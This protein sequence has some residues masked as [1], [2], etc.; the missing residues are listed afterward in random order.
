MTIRPDR[1]ERDDKPSQRSAT[2]FGNQNRG[3]YHNR[4][5]KKAEGMAVSTW[6]YIS[7]L[8]VSRPELINVLRQMGQQ[9]KWPQKMKALDSFRNP[10]FWC[11]FHRDHSHKTEDCIALKIDVSELLRKGHLREFLSEK[12]KSHLSD[13]TMGRPTEAAPI[14]QPRQDRV[15]HVISGATMDELPSEEVSAVEEGETWMTPLIRYLE[16]DILPEDRSEARKI[17]NQDAS[18]VIKLSP[19]VL[20][21]EFQEKMEGNNFSILVTVPVALKGGS[22]YLLW[23]RLVKT[24]IGRLGLWSHIT[25]D[26]PKPVAKETDEDSGTSGKLGFS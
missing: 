15:I 16:A 23:S 18:C 21:F 2:D 25:D 8:S 14:S 1:T 19:V 10:G 22:N 3:R 7:H 24:A 9:V 20:C 13:E 5:I 4:P 17:K 11:D 26:G 12:A 6:P